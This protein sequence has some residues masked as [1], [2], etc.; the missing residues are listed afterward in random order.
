MSVSGAE[1][2]ALSPYSMKIQ[3]AEG[4]VDGTQTEATVHSFSDKI[5]ITIS[6]DGRVSQWVHEAHRVDVL[7]CL[8]WADASEVGREQPS[9]RR[10]LSPIQ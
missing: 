7:G 5:L 2:A 10:K 3:R 9:A 1:V 8:I 6:Q 4:L